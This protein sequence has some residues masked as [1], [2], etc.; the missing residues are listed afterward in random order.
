VVPKYNII[1]RYIFAACCQP[2]KK[3]NEIAPEAFGPG[4]IRILSQSGRLYKN[5]PQGC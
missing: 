3:Y 5:L 4:L 1:S 2:V